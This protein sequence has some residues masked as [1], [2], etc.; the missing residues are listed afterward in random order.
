MR[1]TW[2]RSAMSSLRGTLGPGMS[3]SMFSSTRSRSRS[4][5]SCRY[6]CSAS[7][8]AATCDCAVA[9][10]TRDAFA[11]ASP[12]SSPRK[13]SESRFDGAPRSSISTVTLP[14]AFL[15][16][17]FGDCESSRAVA[18]AATASAL[19]RRFRDRLRLERMVPPVEDDRAERRVV[20]AD[21]GVART[22]RSSAVVSFCS[23]ARSSDHPGMAVVSCMLWL[24]AATP[25]SL[26]TRS[27]VWFSDFPFIMVGA[28]VGRSP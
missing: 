1:A 15:V 18:A 21:A 3:R 13:R 23:V 25:P 19:L 8:A 2:S 4:K 7:A 20:S 11:R 12:S 26:S 9:N 28:M 6:A 14:R 16:L 24:R 22:L 27:G 17:G 10:C 5:G